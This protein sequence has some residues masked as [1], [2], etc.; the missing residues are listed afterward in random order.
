MR[1]YSPW[2]GRVH[3]FQQ[4]PISRLAQD[5]ERGCTS[6]EAEDRRRMGQKET[7]MNSAARHCFGIG[8]FNAI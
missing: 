3:A 6:H 7:A 2:P 1:G 5:E 8:K 4:K